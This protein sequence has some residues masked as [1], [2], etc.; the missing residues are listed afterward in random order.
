[1]TAVLVSID[2]LGAWLDEQIAAE[3]ARAKA[4]TEHDDEAFYEGMVD[5]YKLVYREWVEGR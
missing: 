2:T 5:A 3:K 4:A 1:M